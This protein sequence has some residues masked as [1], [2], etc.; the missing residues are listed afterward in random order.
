MRVTRDGKPMCQVRDPQGSG[1]V[2]WVNPI[3]YAVLRRVTEGRIAC[4]V[5]LHFSDAG[6]AKTGL[7]MDGERFVG[8]TETATEPSAILHLK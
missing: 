1:P 7:K 2:V 3:L 6:L 4:T 8:V 5:E